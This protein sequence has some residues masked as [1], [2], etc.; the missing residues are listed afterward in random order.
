M[1][2]RHQ[3]TLSTKPELKAIQIFQNHGTHADSSLPHPHL[4]LIT[5]PIVPHQLHLKYQITTKYYQTQNINLYQNLYQTKLN[6]KEHIIIETPK[7]ITFTPFTSHIPY[8][9]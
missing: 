7:F 4:Q 6:T 9:T 8:Q 5:T 3:R 2:Q 1:L